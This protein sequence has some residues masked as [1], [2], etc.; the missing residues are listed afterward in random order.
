MTKAPPVVT[1]DAIEEQI[2]DVERARL[3][4]LVSCDISVA[5]EV[6]APDFQLVTPTGAVFSRD[7]YLGA[8]AAGHINYVEWEPG[9]ISVRVHGNAAVIRYQAALEVVFGGHLVPRA[10]YWH[11]DTYEILDGRWQAVW[12][13]ATEIR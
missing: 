11:T 10:A 6:H 13:H 1:S 2:R 7:G 3:R 8:I 12:S 4:A 9:F 5:S